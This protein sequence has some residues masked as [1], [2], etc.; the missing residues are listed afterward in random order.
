MCAA[1]IVLKHLYDEVIASDKVVGSVQV[2]PEIAVTSIDFFAKL[3]FAM[4][5][6]IGAGVISA[7]INW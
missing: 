4:R 2:V 3:L 5:I 1:K 7:E 6:V